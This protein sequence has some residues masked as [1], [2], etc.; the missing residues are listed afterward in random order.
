MPRKS[1]PL[2]P[3]ECCEKPFY[4]RY[5][6]QSTCGYT[7]SALLREGFKRRAQPPPGSIFSDMQVSP[8]QNAVPK[9]ERSGP[10]DTR[11]RNT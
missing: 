8:D 9:Q 1:Y 6:G 2:L 5:K 10:R 3:C 7:C 4:Q 11:S